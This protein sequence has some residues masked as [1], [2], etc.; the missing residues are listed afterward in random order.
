MTNLVSPRVRWRAVDPMAEHDRLPAPLR[1]WL[2]Q[3]ALP[4]SAQSAARLW[5]RALRET[6]C[7]DMA[8]ARLRAAEAKTLAREA[9]RV[10]GHGYPAGV[11][12]GAFANRR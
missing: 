3:A 9:A 2:A 7:P 6:R 1:I 12:E 4:W 11:Q 10:W 8:L 5:Q